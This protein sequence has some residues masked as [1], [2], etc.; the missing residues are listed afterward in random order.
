A[1]SRRPHRIRPDGPRG[2]VGLQRLLLTPSVL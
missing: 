2:I 1:T